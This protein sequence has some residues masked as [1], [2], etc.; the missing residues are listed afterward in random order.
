MLPLV[1]VHQFRAADDASKIDDLGQAMGTASVIL[2]FIQYIP[3]LLTTY[4]LKGCPPPPPPPARARPAR[5]CACAS[6]K[7]A[8][9]RS[10]SR[11]MEGG[12]L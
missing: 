5:A 12:C 4:R 10:V 3:Q 2:T 8:F 9:Q 1:F 6:A 7:V 11:R